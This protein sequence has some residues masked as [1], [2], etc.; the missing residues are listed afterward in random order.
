M[1]EVIATIHIN[2]PRERVFATI[3]DP[4][5]TFL[6]GN[7]VTQMDVGSRRTSGVGTVYRWS[8]TL[9]L[10]LRFAFNEV[11]TEWVEPER[12]AYRAVSGWE[13][14]AVNVLSPEGGGTRAT[15]TLRYRLAGLWWWLLPKWL[16]RLGCRRALSN[17]RRLV[18][19][20]GAR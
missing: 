9:P 19:D 18:M 12:L 20:G 2:A 5:K 10:G 7:P 4:R 6:T 15:F 8:F 16:V 11:V 13:M 1:N 14:E 17:V 3:T